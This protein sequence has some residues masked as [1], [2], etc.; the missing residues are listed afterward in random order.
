V[1][2]TLAPSAVRPHLQGRFG[3]PL[4]LYAERCSSTQ[5]LLPPD[6]PE[7]A[8]ALSEEQTQGRGRRG[9]EWQGAPGKDLLFS[10]CLRPPVETARLASFT[11]V[12]AEAIAQAIASLGVEAT[13]KPPN[14][15][16][17]AGRKVAGILAEASAGRVVLGVGV[18][19]AQ[20][21]G[22]LPERPVFPAS[23]LALELGYSIDRVELL[24]S[25]LA[26]LERHYEL[27]L[28]ASGV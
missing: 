9:R 22:D 6:A 8:L 15:V 5:D 19:V 14:D 4:Y 26:Q 28:T 20:E 13:V 18:N 16:L 17:I 21:A 2:G 27:W 3:Q 25:A 24:A 11:P 7:G 23:S 1:T 12:A 10:L